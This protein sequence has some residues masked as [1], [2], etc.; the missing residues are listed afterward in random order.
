MKLKERNISN[1]TAFK[2]VFICS[3]KSF[4]RKGCNYTVSL[5]ELVIT[6]KYSIRDKNFNCIFLSSKQVFC[7]YAFF[8]RDIYS[9]L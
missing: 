1:K 6:V 4:S 8:L 7:L 9:N 5:N 3:C 2:E